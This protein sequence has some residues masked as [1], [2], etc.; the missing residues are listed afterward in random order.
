MVASSPS[1][2]FLLD[3]FRFHRSGG[4]MLRQDARGAFTP[5][6]IGSRALDVLGV[7][8][9]RHG[10]LVTK[11]EIIAAVW[12]NTV[13]AEANLTVQNIGTASRAGSGSA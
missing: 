3:D 11:D 9:K 6:M 7:L 10:D 5:V 8:L 4:E 2:F 1:D 13:V 12:P